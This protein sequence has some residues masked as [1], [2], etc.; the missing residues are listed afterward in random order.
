MNFPFKFMVFLFSQDN[1]DIINI[2]RVN[3]PSGIF[4]FKI[5]QGGIGFTDVVII[6]ET[7]LNHRRSE[8]TFTLA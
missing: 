4:N 7:L 8:L 6:I 2:I 5:V 1:G 3:V